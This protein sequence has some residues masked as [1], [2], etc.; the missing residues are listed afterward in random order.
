MSIHLRYVVLLFLIIHLC[1]SL[2]AFSPR[3]LSALFTLLVL[4]ARG[5]FII[6]HAL[7]FESWG[8]SMVG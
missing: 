8:C 2:F 6:N 7:G 1:I 3:Y 4:V 5:T